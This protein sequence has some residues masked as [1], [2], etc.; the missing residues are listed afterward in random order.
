MSVLNK[1]TLAICVVLSACG[2]MSG[3]DILANI[4]KG[5]FDAAQEAVEEALAANPDQSDYFHFLLG[6][7][8]I[9]QCLSQ[10]CHGKTRDHFFSEVMRAFENVF[11][12]SV[13]HG[14]DLVNLYTRFD[15][16]L[17]T[18]LETE[19]GIDT[20]ISLY[21]H[22]PTGE[23][24]T[25]TE[26]RLAHTAL[27]ALKVGEEKQAYRIYTGLLEGSSDLSYQE[28]IVRMVAVFDGKKADIS[29]DDEEDV[30]VPEVYLNTVPYVLY[31]AWKKENQSNLVDGLTRHIA[32]LKHPFLMTQKGKAQLA[33]AFYHMARDT[34]FAIQATGATSSEKQMPDDAQ[35][36]NPA[37]T[38]FYLKVLKVAL[39]VNPSSIKAWEMFL[40]PATVYATTHGNPKILFD[41]FTPQSVPADVISLYNKSLFTLM[42]HEMH[43]GRS[44]LGIIQHV[45]LP[46]DNAQEVTQKVG[47]LLNEAM[48]KAVDS[49]NY[50]LVYE[51]ASFQPDIAKLSRQK[52]VSITI[53][54]LEKKWQENDFNGMDVLAKF[55]TGTVGIDFS[56]ESFLMQ[57]FDDHLTQIGVQ[58][59]LSAQ[60]ADVL[61]LPQKNAQVD[62]GDKFKYLKT[63]FS[64]K[65]YVLDNL[66]KSLIVKAQGNYGVPN[67]LYSLYNYFSDNFP[68]EERKNYLVGAIQESLKA[69]TTL[70]GLEVAALGV[71]LNEKFEEIPMLFVVEEALSRT[72]GLGNIRILWEEAPE[73]FMKSMRGAKPQYATL[74]RAIDAYESGNHEDAAA[75]FTVLSDAAL[76]K[77]ARP[78][79][80]EYIETVNSHAGLYVSSAQDDDMKIFSIALEVTDA[81]RDDENTQRTDVSAD[82]DLLAVNIQFVSALGSLKVMSDSDLTESFGKVMKTTVVGHINPNTMEITMPNSA[83]MSANLIY[84]FEKIFGDVNALRLE[85]QELVAL[86]S[87]GEYRFEKIFMPETYVPHGK[88]AMTTQISES[89]T[90]EAYVLPVGTILDLDIDDKRDIPH[91]VDGMKIIFHPVTGEIYHPLSQ[92]PQKIEG[93]Y[94]PMTNLLSLTYVYAFPDGGDVDATA[95]CQIL[96]RTVRCAAH[97]TH[98]GRHKFSHIVSGARVQ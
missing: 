90:R 87:T 97:N 83:D 5:N 70:S 12:L 77:M 27:H 63:Y 26:Y 35:H 43:V 79:L 2:G 7:I 45:I 16:V 72:Q 78:Y 95:R 55:L 1:L 64:K 21:T 23:L 25:A 47:D 42:T 38:A 40:E 92:G 13:T 34:N 56:L 3:S 28:F 32:K 58:D 4:D 6:E 65:P 44:I 68:P 94:D 59:L 85:G 62:L 81:T 49:E 17:N 14:S 18:V 57:S 41:K 60:R 39:M 19:N 86:T 29:K 74:M 51:Y 93:F 36:E 24:K 98:W 53:S 76:I 80:A 61:L 75:M 31:Y 22:I 52:I 96:D 66:L 54:A 88:Y 10:G 50:E 73:K 84:S 69:D 37:L 9:R 71:E 46:A 82:T 33:N 11:S 48:I 89:D 67:A 15:T 91:D 20:L 30:V 8:K